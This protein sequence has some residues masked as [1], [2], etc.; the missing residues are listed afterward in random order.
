MSV[1]KRTQVGIVGCGPAGLLLSHLLAAAG[2]ESV[3]L[4][5]RDRAYVEARNRAGVLEQGTVDLM[6]QA[7]VTEGLTRDGLVH[8]GIRIARNGAQHRIALSD[9]TDGQTV[10]VYGQG[11]MTRDLIAARLA[12]GAPILFDALDVQPMDFDGDAPCL[13]YVLDGETRELA[14]DFIAGCDGY[15]GICRASLPNAA[16]RIFERVYPFTWLGLLA[17]RP[18]VAEEL[19]Y[20]THAEGFALFSMRGPRL[21][22]N[23]LQ[24]RAGEEFDDWPVEKIWEALA[25]RLGDSLPVEPGPILDLIA[26]PMRSF[27]AEPLRHGRMFLAG[28]AAHIVPPTGA[29]GLNLAASDVHYLSRGLIAHYKEGTDRWLDRYSSDALARIW[30]TERF[31]WWMTELLHRYP[32]GRGFEDRLQGAELDYLLSSEAAQRVFAENYVGLP[33]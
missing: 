3:I 13:R 27:V 6:R 8:T 18:P 2:I 20:A 11:A 29:K 5:R 10:T 22:R 15:F 21:S 28:D 23:Y 7:G 4:E 31:S 17:D 24:V 16:L 14:C 19:I 12:Q 25:R 30:K 33:Y 1:P 26:A 32:G 9:L